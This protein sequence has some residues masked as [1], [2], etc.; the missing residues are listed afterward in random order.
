[1]PPNGAPAC[2]LQTA[3]PSSQKSRGSCGAVESWGH[4]HFARSVPIRNLVGPGYDRNPIACRCARPIGFLSLSKLH[5]PS[6]MPISPSSAS[7]AQNPSLP[8][9][10]PPAKP[11]VLF[12]GW[13]Y[14]PRYYAEP[15]PVSGAPVYYAQPAMPPT[16]SQGLAAGAPH[17]APVGVQVVRVQEALRQPILSRGRQHRR[18]S[19]PIR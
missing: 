12:A 18:Q 2:S 19:G 10:W 5:A 1:M 13:G 15:Y 6:V 11:G 3:A 16:F 7:Q 14:Y 9:D 17:Y 4:G 8:Q